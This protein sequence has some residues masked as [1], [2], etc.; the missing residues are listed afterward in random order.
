VALR[1]SVERDFPDLLPAAVDLPFA[2]FFVA[3]SKTRA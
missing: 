1:L 3:I 2:V